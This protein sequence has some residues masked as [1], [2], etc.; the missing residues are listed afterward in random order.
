M[1]ETANSLLD[2]IKTLLLDFL[3]KRTGYFVPSISGGRVTFI[4]LPSRERIERTFS[5]LSLVVLPPG[6]GVI[7]LMT[8][9]RERGS[10]QLNCSLL[11]SHWFHFQ[12][13]CL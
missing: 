7:D 6:G 9:I 12:T 8:E 2:R 4:P 10:V 3:L 13:A 5:A 11:A 1:Q